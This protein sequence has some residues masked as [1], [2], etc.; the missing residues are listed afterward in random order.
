[1]S[2][3]Q[4]TQ[5]A[6]LDVR[7][8]IFDF[9][10]TL[11]DSSEGVIDCANFA[12]GRLGL[13]AAP[14]DAIRRTIGMSLTRT[15][16]ELAGGAKP[17]R[18]DD[19]TRL[20]IERADAVM[21]DATR[22]YDF[23]PRLFAALRGHGVPI[24]IVS[25]KYRRR[26]DAVLRREGLG[27]YADVIVGGE[28]VQTLKP[29]PTGL[30]RAAAALGCAPAQCLYVGDTAVDAETARRA[31]IPFA[32]ALSG[33]TPRAAF[34]EYALALCLDSAAQLPDALGIR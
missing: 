15:Y 8:V 1:M 26:I 30:L 32:A 24:G 14:A 18:A 11:A 5:A 13:P 7:A 12:L 6:R 29:D 3:A 23:T 28:D 19:F 21:H 27:G 22:L 33:V 20:F 16:A 34:A 2:A 31:E 9:D 4:A 10:Y 25:S 17:D